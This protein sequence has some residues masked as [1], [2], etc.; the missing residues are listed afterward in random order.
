MLISLRIQDKMYG[1]GVKIWSLR[2]A[3][4]KK[5]RY[6]IPRVR[7]IHILLRSRS[8]FHVM[9]RGYVLCTVLHASNFRSLSRLG[10][11][12]LDEGGIID[13]FI[14]SWIRHIKA[15]GKK[16]RKTSAQQEGKGQFLQE[17]FPN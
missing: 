16:N 15:L 7:N 6:F 5:R 3:Q 8:L 11:V 1:W 9:V 14:I 4:D 2:L 13:F 12:R 10:H 17:K